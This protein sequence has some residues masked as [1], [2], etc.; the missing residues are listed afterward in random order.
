MNFWNNSIPQRA[1]IT[2]LKTH[3]K[4]GTFLHLMLPVVLLFLTD[5]FSRYIYYYASFALLTCL[6]AFARYAHCADWYK[7]RKHFAPQEWL[8]RFDFI[9]VMQGLLIGIAGPIL[10]AHYS[11]TSFQMQFYFLLAAIFSLGSTMSFAVRPNTSLFFISFILLPVS[12]TNFLLNLEPESISISIGIWIF[13]PFCMAQNRKLFNNQMEFNKKQEA[14]DFYDK[15][16]HEFIDSIPGLVSWL[17]SD[18][19]YEDVNEN[20]FIQYNRGKNT[21]LGQK[22]DSDNTPEAIIEY[23]NDFLISPENTFTGEIEYSSNAETKNYLAVFTKY[24]YS[25]DFKISILCLDI[26]DLKIKEKEIESQRMLLLENQKLISLGEMAGS[27]AH[28]VNNPLAIISGK[29]H[30]ILHKIEQN[31]I[32][33]P[34][35]K[36]YA[37][38]IYETA[39]RIKKII[40]SLRL[41]ANEGHIGS[42]ATYTI[43][44][45]IQPVL[46]ITQSRL[47]NHNINF[48]LDHEVPDAKLACGLIEMGQVLMNMIGNSIHAVEHTD[49]EKWIRIHTSVKNNKVQIRFSDCGQGIPED[50]RSRIFEP[51]FSTKR[52]EKG[53]GVGLSISRKLIQKQGGTLNYDTKALYTTFVIELP[54]AAAKITE[55]AA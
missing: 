45:V 8:R 16:L 14:I 32:E 29:A 21:L 11:L 50:I 52:L 31:K 48:K 22:V 12:I 10:V 35:L 5:F 43:K 13:I 26:T 25:N 36:S 23:L 1:Q 2:F 17:S 37:T 19:R 49:E 4:T 42:I 27:I 3:A 53:S 6:T 28:E 30:V 20:F 41:L 55:N 46:D 7:K 9:I 34:E 54:L 38:Q 51:F 33:L 39:F 15:R 18:L 40:D 47:L 44:D 24:N